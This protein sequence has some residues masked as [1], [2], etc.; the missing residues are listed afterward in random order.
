MRYHRYVALGDSTAEGLDDPDG[1]GGYR[2]WADRLAQRIDAQQPGLLYANLAIRGRKTHQVRAEQLPA[3]LAMRPDLATVATGVNDV[4]RV[5]S[6]L[7]VV[8]AHLVDIFA[9]LTAAGATV[10][11]MTYPDP[12]KVM[13]MGRLLSTRMRRLNDAVRAAAAATG[14]LVCDFADEPL[15][16][17]LSMWSPD[18]IHASTQGHTRLAEAFAWR[19]GLAGADRSWAEVPPDAVAVRGFARLG[20][21]AGWAYNH[22]VPF[23]SRHLR[24]VSLGDGMVPKRAS[25]QPVTP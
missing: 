22:F 3:A 14:A 13:A 21:E 15:A 7:D 8:G 12:A 11:T 17:D 2:G 9:A 16:A 5:T 6:D 19:L 10:L 1:L 23:V 24:G 18:R 20:A 4:L 25:L